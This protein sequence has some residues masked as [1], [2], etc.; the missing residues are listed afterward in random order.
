M[1]LLEL[2]S[3]ACA[4]TSDPKI[5]DDVISAIEQRKQDLIQLSD[6]IWAFSETALKETRSAKALADYA[7]RE[8][9]QVERGVAGLPTAFTASFGTGGPLIGIVGEYDAL[10]GISQKAVPTKQA[11]VEGAAGHGCG[12]NLFGTASLAAAV[13]IKEQIAAGRLKGTIRFYGCPAEET[14]IG[15]VQMARAGLFDDLDV[16]LAWHPGD[17]TAADTDGSRAMVDFLVEFHGRTAHASSSPWIGRSALD[18]LELFTH[19]LNMMREHVRPSVRMHYVITKG[20]DVPNVVPDYAQLWCWVRDSKRAGVQEV[21]ERL[22][23]VAAG[24]ALMAEVESRLTVQSGVHEMLVS[25]AGSKLLQANLQRLGPIS[26]TAEEQKF[27][28]SIQREVGVEPKGLDGSV[29]PLQPQPVD[30]PGGSTDVADVSWIVPT[31]NLRVTASPVGVPSHAWPVV[32]CSGMSIGHK[33][34]LH[35]A[36]VLAATMVDLFTKPETRDSIKAEFRA[37]TKGLHYE[38]LVPGDAHKLKQ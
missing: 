13:A 22:R 20:G 1:V 24:A 19:A 29:R 33:G 21:L 25:E 7:E 34:M 38:P 23:K 26:Y 5:K 37:K 4:T 3:P 12:H 8:G 11:M 6:Q 16:C 17:K 2:M 28:Q 31:L 18:G 10:P 35:A 30:P 9:F 32:A 27:A 15:K 14:L 36:K